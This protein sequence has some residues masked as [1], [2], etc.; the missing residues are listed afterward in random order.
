MLQFVVAQQ[1]LPIERLAAQVAEM[2]RIVV[3]RGVLV[4]RL[5]GFEF[6]PTHVTPEQILRIEK[7]FK[8]VLRAYAPGEVDRPASVDLLVPLA[9]GVTWER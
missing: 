1:E 7:N 9:Q 3:G 6:L 5:F 8:F 2:L 4:Q